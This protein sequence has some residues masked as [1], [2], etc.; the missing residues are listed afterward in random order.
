MAVPYTRPGVTVREV[1][2]PSVQPLPGEDTS[3]CIIGP[4]RGFQSYVETFVLEDSVPQQLQGTFVDLD[5][6]V[7]TD[8]ADLTSDP[9]VPSTLVNSEDYDIDDS[10]LTTTGVVRIARSM[11]TNIPDGERITMYFENDAVPTP[12]VSY[13]EKLTLDGV[14]AAVPSNRT[15]DTEST[16]IIVQ[17]PGLV[18][19]SDFVITDPGTTDAQIAGVA[20]PTVIGVYQAI[21]YDYNQ[22]VLEQWEVTVNG[23][24]TG[25]D[26]TVTVT[27]GVENATTVAIAYDATDVVFETA[28]NAALATLTDVGAAASR[29]TRTGSGTIG[30]PYTWVMTL[31]AELAGANLDSVT[32]DGTNLTGGTSPTA[33]AVA[34]VTG[35]V[36]PLIKNQTLQLNST[37][38]VDLP[39]DSINHVIKNQDGDFT[40]EAT[41]YQEGTTTD[42]DYIL[43][44][45]GATLTISRSA[46][47]TTMS[48]S[49][50]RITV[51]VEYQAT[52]KEY[53]NPT[54]V[55]SQIDAEEKY[56]PAMNSSGEIVSPVSFATALAFANGAGNVII[57]ALFAEDNAGNRSAPTGIATD[58]ESSLANIRLVENLNVI[59]PIVS[60]GGLASNDGLIA[61]IAGKVRTHIQSQRVNNQRYQMAI[62]GSD[63]TQFGQGSAAA[64]R[65]LA[66]SFRGTADAEHFKV[67]SPAA[68]RMQNPVTGSE[69][70]IGGQYAAACLA[71]MLAARPVQESLTRKT[72][73]G[74][75]GVAETRTPSEKDA[76]GDAGLTVLHNER[77]VLEVRHSIT[78]S[79]ETVAA[80]ETN[81][82][83]AKHYHI[84]SMRATLDQLIGT[85]LADEEA[86]FSVQIAAIAALENMRLNG[87]L[88]GFDGVQA[89]TVNNDPTHVELRYR[90]LPAFPLNYITVRFSLNTSTG[91]VTAE[92]LGV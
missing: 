9:F 23:G 8:A 38:P 84:S 20:V 47:T 51:R 79:N 16:S 73:S 74:L 14:G 29:V 80:R 43:N 18:P 87:V 66:S 70:I 21:T 91:T 63:S 15:E 69:F 85:V 2:N 13:T 56:G 72:I 19:S 82:V 75:L 4:A 37:T 83:R 64:L 28:V 26:F 17:S 34:G 12:A 65:S 40:V 45:S 78:T 42:L 71:G 55:F 54:R 5:T 81:V 49:T 7:V 60:S 1:V 44:G 10:E 11:Q 39:D 31:Q 6:L 92:T 76:D 61:A 62:I 57:Q 52:P 58:W 59:V 89:R 86:P 25:G 22:P 3:I 48:P 50:N 24:P 35:D 77:G 30:D 88:V 33:S 41:V 46:G 67:I 36:G 90:Y 53:W 32:A 68:F 27:R